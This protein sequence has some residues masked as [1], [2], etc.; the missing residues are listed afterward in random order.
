M[1]I[2]AVLRNYAIFGPSHRN[3]S[4]GQP[5]GQIVSLNDDRSPGTRGERYCDPDQ[6]CTVLCASCKDIGSLQYINCSKRLML[7]PVDTKTI[8]APEHA[9]GSWTCPETPDPRSENILLPSS[10]PQ[11]PK[12]DQNSEFSH[13]QKTKGQVAPAMATGTKLK[14]KVGRQLVCRHLTA[15]H[16]VSS[17]QVTCPTIRWGPK[18][19]RIMFNLKSSQTHNSEGTSISYLLSNSKDPFIWKIVPFPLKPPFSPKNIGSPRCSDVHI[20]HQE[21]DEQHQQERQQQ[22]VKVL[23]LD[24]TWKNRVKAVVFRLLFWVPTWP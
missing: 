22:K 9:T 15:C 4:C 18:I 20:K 5:F 16:L 17:R 12:T 24:L 7:K 23:Q 21:L 11:A 2:S 14:K 1:I 19:Q 13:P 8:K 6:N 10:S 3:W